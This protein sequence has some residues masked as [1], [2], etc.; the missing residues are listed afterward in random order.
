LVESKNLKIIGIDID[1]AYVK[2]GKLAVQEAG[3]T[4]R[5]TIDVASVYDGSDVVEELAKKIGATPDVGRFY[6]D[7]VYFSGSFS[8]LPNPVAALELMSTLVKKNDKGTIYITQTYQRQKPFFLPFVK[9]LLKYVTTIDFGQCITE[10]EVMDTFEESGLGV[11]E[12]SVILGS[13][14]TWF[15]AA[16]L[17]ILKPGKKG[18]IQLTKSLFSSTYTVALD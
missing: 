12:H 2:I 16:Y 13:I 3:L 8:L 17:S 6:V 1:E 11:I 7:A 5:I 14:D 9:P 18:T 15:Q 4:D 10:E